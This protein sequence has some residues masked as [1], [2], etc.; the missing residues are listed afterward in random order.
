M[1]E[2]AECTFS[3]SIHLLQLFDGHPLNKDSPGFP[4]DK[5]APRLQNQPNFLSTVRNDLHIAEFLEYVFAEFNANPRILMTTEWNA[6]I[7]VED[8][9]GFPRDR[10]L[11]PVL[12]THTDQ[13]GKLVRTLDSPHLLEGT[14][15]QSLGL[16]DC[17]RRLA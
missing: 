17:A 7:W 4:G 5:L 2:D 10:S 15:R 8:A 3:L 16:F 1:R 13:P 9:E 12:A 14:H 6:D 11:I